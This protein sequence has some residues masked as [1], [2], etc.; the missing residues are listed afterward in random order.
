MTTDKTPDT[1]YVVLAAHSHMD[2]LVNGQVIPT[3]L[4]D[5]TYVLYA[6]A[7]SEEA[8]EEAAGR[9]DVIEVTPDWLKVVEDDPSEGA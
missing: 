4:P 3:P 9:F 8:F 2:V 5:G 1:F 7:D 6:F